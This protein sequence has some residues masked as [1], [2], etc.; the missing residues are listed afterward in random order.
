MA[1][2]ERPSVDRS[3]QFEIDMN[4][5][6]ANSESFTSQELMRERQVFIR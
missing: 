5:I 1:M 6:D 2:T 3:K 4:E